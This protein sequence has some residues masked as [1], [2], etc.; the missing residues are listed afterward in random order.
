MQQVKRRSKLTALVLA[1]ISLIFIPGIGQL[2]GGRLG[3]AF[4]LLGIVF[5]AVLSGSLGV[6]NHVLGAVLIYAI[7]FLIAAYLAYDAYKLNA[8]KDGIKLHWYN[9]WYY[10]IVFIISFWFL[11]WVNDSLIA[12]YRHFHIM[13]SNNSPTLQVGDIVMASMNYGHK[14]GLFLISENTF[15]S[16]PIIVFSSPKYKVGSFIFFKKPDDNG[17]NKIFI[18]KIV[19]VAGDTFTSKSGPIKVTNN[20]VLVPI[21]N[22]DY[23]SIPYQNIEGKAR[24]ILWS[25]NISRIGLRVD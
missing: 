12:D 1:L 23:E 17:E 2:Y 15:F 16:F 4:L 8:H 9:K 6:M 21:D 18:R 5:L 11:A 25:A 13:T 22:E 20:N 14:P 24:Y 10:Y 19:A 3:K 7:F